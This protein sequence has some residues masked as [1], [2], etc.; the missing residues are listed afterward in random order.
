MP[1]MTMLNFLSSWLATEMAGLLLMMVWTLGLCWHLQNYL[2]SAVSYVICLP[3]LIL[4]VTL[5]SRVYRYY[6][7]FLLCFIVFWWFSIV[8]CCYN[9]SYL[10]VCPIHFILCASMISQL[11]L[12]NPRGGSKGSMEPSFWEI[13]DKL[14]KVLLKLKSVYQFH[15]HL[16]T[17]RLY[18]TTHSLLF[19]AEALS[20]CI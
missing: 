7:L 15:N 12:M 20:S 18:A 2:Q 13:L 3:K 19:T 4:E 9:I 6:E 14:V 1:Y 17:T 10:E 11:I 5:L 16:C 8:K